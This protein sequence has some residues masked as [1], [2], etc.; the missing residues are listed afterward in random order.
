MFT[1]AKSSFV[2]QAGGYLCTHRACRSAS[3]QLPQTSWLFAG[4]DFLNTNLSLR[5][6]SR[7]L[8]DLILK[9]AMNP[10]G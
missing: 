7:T 3:S 1:K 6:R 10:T 4:C 8:L 5:M 9:G 2:H